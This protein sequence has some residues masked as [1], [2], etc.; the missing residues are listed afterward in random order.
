MSTEK[1]VSLFFWLGLLLTLSVAYF[2][3]GIL[4]LDDYSEGIARFIPAQNHSFQQIIE[5]T[6]IRL[7]FQALLLLALSKLAFFLGI[8]NPTHQ[9][10][11]VLLVIGA[12]VFSIQFFC[13]KRFFREPR[14]IYL[15]TFLASFYFVLPLVYSRPLIENLAGAFLTLSAYFASLYWEREQP[16][17]IAFAVL[18]IAVSALFRFQTGICVVGILLLLALRKD[19][20]GLLVFALS[21]V[22]AF[23]L[24]GLLDWSLTGGFHRSLSAYLHYNV[25]YSSGYGTTPFYT[26]FLL[27]IGLSLP[28]AFLGL[29]KGLNWKKTYQPLLPLVFYFLIFLVAHSIVP[30]KEER[31]MIP[32]LVVFLMLLTPLAGFWLIHP[33]GKW[34]VLF[35]CSLN[36][37]LLPLASFSTP[38][39]NVIGFV[40]YLNDH[41]R[42]QRVH[43][44]KDSLVLVPSAFTLNPFQVEKLE[45]PALLSD[46]F[47]RCSEVLAVRQDILASHPEL[48]SKYETIRAFSPGPLESLLVRLNPHRNLRRGKIY[49]FVPLSCKGFNS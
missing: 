38:Q 17:W 28:P 44:L 15:A 41:P 39:Q 35:F 14:L 24:T 18:S 36:F 48:Q 10:Q 47:G 31:F 1:R 20:R 19:K 11:F 13:A 45:D 16:R 9:L 23:L 29:Y 22:I 49:L 37:L 3:Q 4:A 27:F 5:T 2:N 43:N 21:G 30:H 7:P 25:S 32:V 6:G 12:S 40:Q 8:V 26:F 42:I 33:K 46:D 34:R